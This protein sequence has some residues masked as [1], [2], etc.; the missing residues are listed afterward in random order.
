MFFLYINQIKT[1]KIKNCF[2]PLFLPENEI[3]LLEVIFYFFYWF[4]MKKDP[5]ENFRLEFNPNESESFRNLFLNQSMKR[6]VSRLMK[7]GQK[8]IRLDPIHSALI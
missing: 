2:L 5:G 1:R 8:S 4:S 6:F 3:F 7:N